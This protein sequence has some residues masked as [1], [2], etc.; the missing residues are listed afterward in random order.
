MTRVEVQV[1]AV[2]KTPLKTLD[3][4]PESSCSMSW[5]DSKHLFCKNSFSQKNPRVDLMQVWQLNEIFPSK[6][7]K[8]FA[9]DPKKMRILEFSRNKLVFLIIILWTRRIEV[10]HTAES[11][12]PK[13]WKKKH[14][15]SECFYRQVKCGF[16]NTVKSFWRKTRKLFA[17]CS[18]TIENLYLF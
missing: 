8:S 2:S 12:Q 3:E 15:S 17:Q 11:F 10:W 1:E 5:N 18:K 6:G 4:R 14:F 9:R 13:L 16:Q 7:I